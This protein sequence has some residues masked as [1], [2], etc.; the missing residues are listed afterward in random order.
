MKLKKIEFMKCPGLFITGTDTGVGKT[1]VCGALANCLVAKG[2]RPGVFKP[3]ASGC[4]H[5][6]E[7]LV[8][9]DAEFLAHCANS[10]FTLEQINPVRYV[11]PLAPSVAAER[12]GEPVD[13]EVI[14]RAYR[15]LAERTGL[16][17]VEGVGGVMVPLSKDVL[18]LDL[19]VALGLP[20]LV[21]SGSKLGA[22][23]HTVLTVRACEGAGLT[24]AGVVINGYDV[25]NASLAEESNPQVISEICGVPILS[26]IPSDKVTSVESGRLGKPV[27]SA[28]G[29]VDWRDLIEQGG[30]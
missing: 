28:M 21:V 6:R 30:R 9:A 29:L 27:V 4:V 20:V 2:G 5:S 24:V 10:E 11:E 22:I 12:A 8:S 17:L 26:V 19:M 14:E 13:F 1:V 23:N 16:M 25:E 18:V 3:V 7:G 15:Y